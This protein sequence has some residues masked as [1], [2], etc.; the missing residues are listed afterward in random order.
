MTNE[1]T[2]D[3]DDAP[4]SP[5]GAAPDEA[6]DDAPD[7]GRDD[8]SDALF[9]AVY[10]G[11]EDTVVT[12]LRSGVTAEATDQDGQS[13]LYAA[14]VS[15]EPGAVRL[16]LA[17]G[18]DPERSSGPGDGDLPLC[19]A[20]CG[21]H[22]EVVLALLAAGA[23]PDRR[24]A[25]GFTAL[26][27][28]VGQG[29]AAT[30]EALLAHGAD[31]DLPGPG[32]GV[33]DGEP[34][35]VTAAR[36]GSPSTVRA[37]LRH[38]AGAREEALAEARR[39]TAP[40][41]VEHELHAE[42]LPMAGEGD[43]TVV[44]RIEEDGG[45]TVVVETLRD[46]VPVASLERQ[47]GHGAITTVLEES[48]GLPAPFEELA[49]RALRCGVPERDD[50]REPVAA[51]WRRGDEE[52][53][54]ASLAWLASDDPLRRAFA[55]DVLAGLGMA[56]GERPFADRALP[57]LRESCARARTPELIG[58]CVTALG[59]Q[60]DSAV[61]PEILRHT[62]HPDPGVRRRVTAAL[63]GLVAGDHE[64]G[65]A[66]LT[67]LSADIDNPVRERAT[68]ALAAADADTPGIREA[69]A[70]RLTDPVAVTAAEA[71]RG[72]AAREDPRAVDALARML[73]DGRVAGHARE[74]AAAAVSGLPDAAVRRR[75]EGLLPRGR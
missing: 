72:L 65:I 20:A 10:E 53:F 41:A 13:A 15:D 57:P 39:W 47:T 11:R 56:D 36:R 3:S 12:L 14:A 5:P 69:L 19:G 27:W 18:A 32:G 35:L 46:G 25:Y 26:A 55:A 8:A 59:A 60:G 66:A 70:A 52:S 16:L 58:A 68:T 9:A 17:A 34:P 33:P 67:A 49:G 4:G 29:H 30:V 63:A 1:R 75:L 42:L 73:A 28:A 23:L 62:G 45:V 22:T 31:P 51:L 71:A 2:A 21:G 43:E 48:L 7:D 44:R 61:L 38:G 64:E 54:Q 37:L 50:W 74:T 24:E 40:E 6:P